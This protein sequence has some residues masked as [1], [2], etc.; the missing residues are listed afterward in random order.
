MTPIVTTFG[1]ET[2]K[3]LVFNVPYPITFKREVKNLVWLLSA[4]NGL[5]TVEEISTHTK[6]KKNWIYRQLTLLEKCGIVCDSHELYKYF[7]RASDNV[8]IFGKREFDAPV[9]EKYRPELPPSKLSTLLKLRKSTRSFTGKKL[10]QTQ[11]FSCDHSMRYVPQAG[12]LN[13]LS[14]YLVD[15]DE[16]WCP[17]A[18]PEEHLFKAS[19]AIVVIADMS[20]PKAKY[21]NRGYRYALLEAGHAAQNA[22]LWAAENKLGI[23]EYGGFI[24]SHIKKGLKLRE[25]QEI[26]TVLIVGYPSNEPIIPTSKQTF[27]ALYDQWSKDLKYVKVSKGQSISNTVV[28][29][30]FSNT[31]VAVAGYEVNGKVNTAWGR[32]KNL[33]EAQLKAMAEAIERKMSSKVRV[34]KVSSAVKLKEEFLTPDQ[35]YPLSDKQYKMFP[36]LTPFNPNEKWS[37]VRG[38]RDGKPVYVPVDMVYYPLA[39]K[40]KLSYRTDSNG[41]AAHTDREKAI[42]NGWLELWERHCFMRAWYGDAKLKGILMMLPPHPVGIEVAMVQTSHD[43][44]VAA[45]VCMMKKNGRLGV[46][47]GASLAGIEAAALKAFGEAEMMLFGNSQK[48]IIKSAKDVKTVMDHFYYYQSQKRQQVLDRWFNAE[49]EI[50]IPSD[51]PYQV[52]KKRMVVVDIADERGIHVVKVFDPALIPISFGYGMESFLH[53]AFPKVGKWPFIPHCFA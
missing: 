4:C 50:I 47:G 24:E 35:C 48:V 26:L 18:F 39:K 6:L 7:I 51:K 31:V 19:H 37:W 45:A 49:E 20:T 30:M 27:D 12:G 10:S 46:G 16:S 29:S 53:P 8:P 40:F 34:D 41:I 38:E 21:G 5:R 9:P 15:L 1:R 22:Y 52:A 33:Y 23:L 25:D 28:A 13:A 36:F 17:A 43:G 14:F 44:E 2:K 32:G 42:E 11:L 3:G